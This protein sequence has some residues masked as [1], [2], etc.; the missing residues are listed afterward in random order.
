MSKIDDLFSLLK[1]DGVPETEMTAMLAE[2][3]KMSATKLYTQLVSAL[4]DEDAQLLDE[5]ADDES[6]SEQLLNTLY[7]KYYNQSADEAITQL[8]EKFATEF[9]N[10]YQKAEQI[11]N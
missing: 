9:L 7:Q 8:Q 3:T 6:E 4:S 5:V 1:E 2:L 11:T 10:N